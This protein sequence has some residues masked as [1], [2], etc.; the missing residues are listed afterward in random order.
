MR[1]TLPL[2][3]AG[4][5]ASGCAT[6]KIQTVHVSEPLKP[7]PV[8]SVSFVDHV[9]Q[10]AVLI[11]DIFAQCGTSSNQ[12]ESAQ[13]EIKKQAA[14]VGANMV[15]LQGW[16]TGAPLLGYSDL[17]SIEGRAYVAP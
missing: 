17:F 12:V 10:N 9:P 8:A 6:Q 16:N 7:I 13:F 3:L 1:I 14:S 15:Q 4:F 5:L 11:A 2:V